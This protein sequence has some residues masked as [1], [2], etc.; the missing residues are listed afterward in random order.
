[1]EWNII[2]HTPETDGY[3]PSLTSGLPRLDLAIGRSSRFPEIEANLGRFETSQHR[4]FAPIVKDLL[5]AALATYAADQVVLRRYGEDRWTR[6]IRL[7]VPVSDPAAWQA[8]GEEFSR[9]A[10]FLTGDRWRF[11]FRRLPVAHTRPNEQ[12]GPAAES[13][14]VLFSGGLDSLIG[15]IDLLETG[16]AVS[17]VSH[18]GAGITRS[19]QQCLVEALCARYGGRVQEFPFWVQPPRI[20]G[21][22]HETTLRSRSLLFLALGTAVAFTLNPSRPLHVAENGLISL[23]VPL[24]GARLGSLSTRTTHPHFIQLFREILQKLAI[25]TDVVL[26]YR[27]KTKGEMLAGA[28][29]Q[30][31]ARALMPLTMSCAHPEAQRYTF[32]SVDR[33]CGYCVPC[34]IRRAATTAADFQDAAYCLDARR[35]APPAHTGR[36]KD[37]RAVLMA[38]ARFQDSQLMAAADVLTT[39][40]IPHHEIQQYAEVYRRGMSELRAYLRPQH[41]PTSIQ[42]L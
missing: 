28:A 5:R 34:L 42:R 32:R 14:V 18:H 35:D 13:L 22:Q 11:E 37:L 7:H 36:G 19:V 33:H 38:I 41:A 3:V 2:I 10:G 29:N 40:P 30:E 12:A 26:P 24:T 8:C 39:G 27:F 17:L 20:Q 25:G 4:S 31:C 15:A 1:M 16:Q 23:N 6:E 9:A 21:S